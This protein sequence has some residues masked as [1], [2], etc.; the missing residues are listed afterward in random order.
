MRRMLVSRISRRVLAEHHIA[1][2]EIHAGTYSESSGEPHV[3]IIFTGLDVRRSVERCVKLLKAR[4]A[5][6][7]EK[8]GVGTPTTN[9][10]EVVIDGHLN[11]KFAYIREHLE[12]S[13]HATVVKH[14]ESRNPPAIRATIVASENDV[15]IRI[16]DEGGGLFTPQNQIKS[17]SDLFSFSHVRNATRLEDSRIGALRTFSSSPQGIRATVGEQVNRWQTVIFSEVENEIESTSNNPE[18]E[19][20]VGPHPRIGIGLPMSNIFATCGPS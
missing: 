19:A 13:I 11:T 2:S 5:G 10:P 12:Q 1:L 6:I 8:L 20:G 9:W 17:P 18:K 3:G 4:P 16:S 7:G 14:H 15:G